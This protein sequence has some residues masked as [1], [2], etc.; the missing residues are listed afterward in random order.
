MGVAL[1]AFAM[2]QDRAANYPVKAI[3][4][5]TGS[6]PGGPLDF[7][8]RLAAQKLSEAFGHQV[9]IEPRTGAS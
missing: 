2:A 9:V 6:A 8:A 4:I 3:R 7:S 5:V 1:P